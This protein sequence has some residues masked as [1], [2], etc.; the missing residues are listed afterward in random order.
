[1]AKRSNS[2]DFTKPSDEQVLQPDMN[3]AFANSMILFLLE[4]RR[5]LYRASITDPLTGIQNRS[6]LRAAFERLSAAD[7]DRDRWVVM[8]DLDNF[9]YINDTYGHPVGDRYLQQLSGVLSGIPDAD[10]FRYGGDEF[11]LLLRDCSREEV[12]R[13]CQTI[14][15]RFQA[16]PICQ[17]FCSLSISFGI[18]TLNSDVSPAELIR[19]ADTALYQAKE[20]R[21]VICYA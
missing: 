11:C 6:G 1:M 7:S 21:G 17:E 3:W 18:S 16:S 20:T 10:P 9:K 8:L 15:S 13:L 19:R 14:Q 4:D 12:D 5:R 2:P